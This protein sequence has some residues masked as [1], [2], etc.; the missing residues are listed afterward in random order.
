MRLLPA[1]VVVLAAAGWVGL[2]GGAPLMVAPAASDTA[3]F[4][5]AWTYR[6]GAMLCHQQTGRSFAVRGVQLPVCARCTGL[7]AGGAVG[8]V[9]AWFGLLAARRRA[10]VL[11]LSLDRWRAITVACAI[12]MIAVWAAEHGL[13][14][15]VNNVVR[16]ATALPPG[17]AVAVIVTCWAGGVGFHDS[18]PETAIH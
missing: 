16:F 5:A 4:A 11:R 12:P 1:A 17:A 15:S 10:Q 3:A 13:G 9:L 14:V 8:A 7:Y 6:A 18:P 2:L